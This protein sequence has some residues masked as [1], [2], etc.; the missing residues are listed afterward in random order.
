MSQNGDLGDVRIAKRHPNSHAAACP[1]S[2]DAEQ[3]SI[4]G[5]E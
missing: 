5:E 3:T 4:F 1:V 2:N